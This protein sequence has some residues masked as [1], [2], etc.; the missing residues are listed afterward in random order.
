MLSSTGWSQFMWQC[1]F[2]LGNMFLCCCFFLSTAVMF[3]ENQIWQIWCHK[4]IRIMLI[5]SEMVY[6]NKLQCSWNWNTECS[7]RIMYFK[8]SCWWHLYRLK[9]MWKIVTLVMLTFNQ[10]QFFLNCLYAWYQQ[11]HQTHTGA[12]RFSNQTKDRVNASLSKHW[13]IFTHARHLETAY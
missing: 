6:C 10:L 3:P 5:Y 12:V 7:F 1:T 4:N 2:C 9:K 11:P 8:T 13:K